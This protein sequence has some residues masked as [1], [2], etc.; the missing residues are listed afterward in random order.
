MDLTKLIAG[1][2]GEVVKEGVLF[3]LGQGRIYDTARGAIGIP[4]LGDYELPDLPDLGD[5]GALWKALARFFTTLLSL[6]EPQKVTVMTE[7]GER[8][9]TTPAVYHYEDDPTQPI[10]NYDLSADGRDRFDA[11]EKILVGYRKRKILVTPEKQEVISIK[12]EDSLRSFVMSTWRTF[13]LL[14][15]IPLAQ[16]AFALVAVHA[17]IKYLAPEVSQALREEQEAVINIATR[18]SKESRGK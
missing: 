1:K 12:E 8:V 16:L 11:Q 18:T 13:E 15:S 6:V 10:Y 7:I 3:H 14:S 9:I 2:G 17:S 5:I 4:T